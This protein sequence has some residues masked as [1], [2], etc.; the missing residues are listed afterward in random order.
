MTRQT[1]K[2]A[3]GRVRPIGGPEARVTLEPHLH[4]S[5]R[6][7]PERGETENFRVMFVREIVDPAED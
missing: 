6:G 5:V 7:A 3:T 2:L 1:R 4:A